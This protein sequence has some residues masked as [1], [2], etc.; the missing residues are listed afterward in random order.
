MSTPPM[1][2]LGPEHFTFSLPLIRAICCKNVSVAKCKWSTIQLIQFKVMQCRLVTFTRDANFF[3]LSIQII[4]P[5]LFKMSAFVTFACF[6]WCKPLNVHGSVDRALFNA[7][8]NVYPHNWKTWLTQQTK[9]RNNVT[10]TSSS[11]RKKKQISKQKLMK[12]MSPDD[13]KLTVLAN[14]NVKLFSWTFTFRKVVRQ[15]IWGEVLVTLRANLSGA[16]YCYRSCL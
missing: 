8:L 12:E 7:V 5:H 15:Q 13:M 6:E 14:M 3:C 9:Y 11:G 1:F 16:V 2:H 10:K 4:L